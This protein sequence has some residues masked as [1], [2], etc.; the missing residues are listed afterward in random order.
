ME[1]SS[2]KVT[3]IHFFLFG[4]KKKMTISWHR[5]TLGNDDKLKK[6]SLS[7]YDRLEWKNGKSQ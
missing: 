2:K 4:S 3:L 5:V 1:Y 6:Y 7:I